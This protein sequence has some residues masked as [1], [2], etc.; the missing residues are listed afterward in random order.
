[1]PK[2]T[3][4]YYPYID[5]PKREWLYSAILYT[6]CLSTIIPFQS[7]Y[8]KDFP[9]E[10][11][12]LKDNGLY[13]PVVIEEVLNR[14]TY[15][16]KTFEDL[17]IEG[18][19]G[20]A[21]QRLKKLPD[22]KRPAVLFRQKLS[23]TIYQYMTDERLIKSENADGSLTTDHNAAMLYMAL[24]A[25]YVAN[26]SEHD[27]IVP[28]TD[29]KAYEKIAFG[30]TQRKEQAISVLLENC[31]PVPDP[32]VKI[33]RIIKFKKDR[34][35]ELLRFQEFISGIQEKIK[36]ASDRQEMNEVL[37]HAREK[38]TLGVMDIKNILDDS[39]IKTLLTSF[40]SLISLENPKLFSSLLAGGLITTPFHPIAGLAIGAIGVTGTLASTFLEGKRKADQSD[41]SYV[42]KAVKEGIV[43]LPG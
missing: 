43:N 8:H 7:V 28:A 35:Q 3:L 17:F 2:R 39:N 20:E 31:L 14:Y 4:L 37:I 30:L 6:D 24:L 38:I 18:V 22:V 42:F 12:R 23:Y 25:Q 26:T 16:F 15:E 29:L 10:L 21:F 34:E 13:E 5:I 32:S 40:N 27:V 41:L 19:S 33:E 11:R 9:D 1:M 36:A